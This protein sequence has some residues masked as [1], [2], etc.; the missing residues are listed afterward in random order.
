MRFQ[1]DDEAKQLNAEQWQLDLLR[2]NPPYCG[3]GPHEDYMWKTGDG[4][5]SRLLWPN[6]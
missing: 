5:D 2:A 3:W 6:V 1:D 4:W